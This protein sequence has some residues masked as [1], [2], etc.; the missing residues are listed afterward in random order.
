HLRANLRLLDADG[1]RVMAE[2]RD[3]AELRERFGARGADAFASHAAAGLARDGL[4][5][6]PDAPIPVSVPG[7]GGVPAFPALHDDEG[8]VSLDVHA[9]RSEAARRHPAGVRRLLAIA[10]AD[11]MRQA[12]RQLPVQPKTALLYAAIESSAPREAGGGRPSD[13]LRADLVDGAFATLTA[14][15]LGEVRDP[16]AFAAEAE[17]VGKALFP[18][19]MR[20]LQQA[21]TILALVAEARAAL[22]GGLMGWARGN[23]DDMHAQLAALA[24][25]GFLR[26]VPAD[27]LASYPRYL[28]ALAI[29]AG[30]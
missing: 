3:L 15:G 18:E 26:D 21:E 14:E 6:F 30:R 4:T 24:P 7:A 2:S 28:K 5:A 25:A 8:H 9:D 23:L 19:A 10:L 12:C 27:A 11:R 22:D 16:D 17:R 13:T 29:R 20:R 1:R